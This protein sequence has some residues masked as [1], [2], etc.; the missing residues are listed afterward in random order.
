MQTTHISTGG[1]IRNRRQVITGRITSWVL[2]L[3]LAWD[4]VIK[5][6]MIDPVV[7]SF[8]ELGYSPTLARPIGLVEL[9]CVIFYLIP[10]TS[11][12][13]AIL[14]TGFLG[15]ATATK[16]RMEDP[17]LLFSV[18]FGILLWLGVFLQN[19]KLRRLFFPKK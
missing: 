2:G 11:V 10:K 16:L 14:L 7:Q 15:G 8:T 12:F 5:L 19:E 13:G 4:A 18:A 17:W 9:I 6:M 3:F 1:M